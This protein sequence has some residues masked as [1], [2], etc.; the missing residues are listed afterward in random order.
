MVISD[1]FQVPVHSMLS[2]LNDMNWITYYLS[3]WVKRTSDIPNQFTSD[4]SMAL[5]NGAVKS[6]TSCG[7]VADYIKVMFDLL[8][9]NTQNRQIPQCFIRIDIAHLMKNVTS[10]D[11]LHNKPKKMRDFFI[12]C[13]AWLLTI[14]DIKQAKE[15]I[16]SVL[17]VATSS[18][19][20]KHKNI[21]TRG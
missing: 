5:L 11:A 15:H 17:V 21:T 19:E 6:F 1:G 2:E 4:M 13:V 10:C 14:D 8:Q 3:D 18:T 16:F 12:R 9:G 7:G 20:G